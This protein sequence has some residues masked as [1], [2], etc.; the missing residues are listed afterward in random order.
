MI[1]QLQKDVITFTRFAKSLRETRKTRK[2]RKL[3]DKFIYI[4]NEITRFCKI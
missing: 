1:I 4:L 3:N 2:T